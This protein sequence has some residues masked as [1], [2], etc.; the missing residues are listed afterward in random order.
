[1]QFQHAIQ[2]YRFNV[3]LAS[4]NAHGFHYYS[5]DFDKTNHPID[6]FR[7]TSKCQLHM[8]SC[9][10]LIGS[11][12]FG[13]NMIC[14]SNP[15][16]LEYKYISTLNSNEPFNRNS[17][18]RYGVLYDWKIDDYK[19][20]KLVADTEFS[21]TSEVWVCRLGSNSWD[22][23]GNIP[24]NVRDI[25]F[26][27]KPLNGIIHWIGNTKVIVSFDIVE[28]RF[29][30]RIKEIQ[31]P[32]CYLE[33]GLYS[34]KDMRVGLL[35]EDLYLSVHARHERNI[36]L[37]VMTDYGDIDSWT[38]I[39][40]LSKDDVNFDRLLPLHYLYKNRE[41]LLQGVSSKGKQ[42]ALVSYNP[43]S[44]RL[45][46]LDIPCIPKRFYATTFV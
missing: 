32:C 26:S 22:S 42:D 4:S 13:I 39:F 28:E 6:I 20:L 36:D 8:V 1:M 17:L 15:S 21:V 5:I 46:T 16:T 30:E 34:C 38:K 35:G 2:N 23:I 31:I 18:L 40:S 14:L 10:G 27:E 3:L 19:L 11:Y 29:E 12:D 43:N 45:M 24:Y 7:F 44:G 25:N 33:D 9:D 37:W 41:I